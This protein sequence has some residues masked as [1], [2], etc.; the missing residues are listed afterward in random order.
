MRIGRLI[1]SAGLA[2]MLAVLGPPVRAQ[3]Y[4]AR[5]VHVDCGYVAGS[6]ADVI[7]RYFATKA[8][9][10][11]GRTFIVDNR[12]G[13][14][15]NIAMEA[16]AR[17]KPDGYTFY[18]TAG[19][20][21]ASS[22]SMFKN[23]KVEPTRDFEMVTTLTRF[24]FV[25]VVD[26]K[27]PIKSVAEL[28]AYLKTKPDHGLYGATAPSGL[29]SSEL[30]KSIVGLNT[31][32]VGYKDALSAMNDL[33]GGQ[34]DYLFGDPVFAVEQ[35]RAGK[36]RGLAVAAAQRVQAIPE[37]PSM[38]EQG[39]PGLDVNT[40]WAVMLPAGTPRPIVDK[41]A[42]WFNKV[43]A[44]DDA[45]KFLANIGADPFPGTPDSARELLAKDTVRW[46]DYIRLA[47]IE[48]QG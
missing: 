48:P 31:T 21:L 47:K 28:T 24:A 2:L 12:P 9:E 16:A 4:P 3:D 45:R 38:A 5:D 33:L 29:V 11:A 37:L 15:G 41:A 13:A 1:G 22:V 36:I 32:Q 39:V 10:L 40:W 6:G 42:G 7:V 23:L 18:L 30:Y 44:S 26:P 20:T 25:L 34:I 46:R 35:M 43:V 8:S 27:R 17:A 19:S 14:F